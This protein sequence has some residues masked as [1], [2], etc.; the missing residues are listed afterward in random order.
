ME[1]NYDKSEIK[2]LKKLNDLAER[3]KKLELMN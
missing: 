2:R 1:E 3:K